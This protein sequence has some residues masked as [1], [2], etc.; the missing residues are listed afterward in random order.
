M[1]TNIKVPV[2]LLLQL[3]NTKKVFLMYDVKD[4]TITNYILSNDLIRYRNS[5]Q[6]FKLTEVIQPQIKNLTIQL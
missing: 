1:K 6:H 2:K 3:I 4:G 5:Y